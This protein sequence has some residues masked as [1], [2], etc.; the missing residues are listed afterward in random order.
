[1][2]KSD[3]YRIPP[4]HSHYLGAQ[5]LLSIGHSH[6][7]QTFVLPVNGSSTDGHVHT[8]AVVTSMADGHHHHIEGITGPAIP[9]PDGSHYHEVLGETKNR[10]FIHKGGYHIPVSYPIHYH[11]YKGRTGVGIGYEP[12]W[13]WFNF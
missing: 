9:M 10:P 4:S 13:R 8:F 3:L 6:S 2:T 1:M 11:V 7:F 12:D 5:T